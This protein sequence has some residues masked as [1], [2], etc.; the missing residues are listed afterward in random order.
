[1]KI[2]KLLVV[3]S[4]I[5][6]LLDG[7]WLGFIAK[8]FYI[9]HL[10][11]LL[12]IKNGNIQANLWAAVI[13]YIALISGL[14]FLALP[15]AQGDWLAALGMGVFFGFVTYATYDFTNL[16][17]LKDW[18]WTIAIFDTCWGMFLCG[19]TAMLTTL[20]VRV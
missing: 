13:V 18:N 10:G 9:K 17:T 5:F 16:A 1:M 6:L 3:A 20:I 14:V 7:L 2:M 4:V 19:I 8:Q 12:N 11:S 15:P